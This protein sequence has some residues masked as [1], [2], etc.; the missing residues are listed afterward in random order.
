MH[1]LL[2]YHVAGDYL[3]RREAYRGEHL[4]RALAAVERGELV[5]GGALSEPADCAVLLFQADSPEP[6]RLFAESDPY[7][8]NGLV[9]SW[10]VRP[11]LTV[12]GRDAQLPLPRAPLPQG[13]IR[14]AGED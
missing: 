13:P 11:W 9:Q 5:L 6:A 8:V 4:A 12:V 10:E 7:V 2:I 3:Q 14:P 1:Y